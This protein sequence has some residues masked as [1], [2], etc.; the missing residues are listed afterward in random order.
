MILASLVALF[1][2]IGAHVPKAFTLFYLA[3]AI[4][5]FW[6]MAKLLLWA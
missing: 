6:C 4:G 2:L 5:T 1:I 3:L